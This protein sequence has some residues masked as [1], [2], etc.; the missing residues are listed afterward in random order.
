MK[1]APKGKQPTPESQ[2]KDAD[3]VRVSE[4]EKSFKFFKKIN[5]PRFGDI[6]II[7]N[8]QSREFL[9]VREKKINDRAE[10]GRQILAARQRISL[11]Y[12]HLLELKDYSVTKQSELCSSFYIIKLFYEYPRS[13]L[14][15]EMQ[16]RQRNGQPFSHVEL[17]HL[18]YQ[19]VG[20]QSYLQSHDQTHGDIQPL[21]IG[22]EK[23]TMNSKLIDRF[24]EPGNALKT[25]QI[26]KN[27][28]IAGHNLYQSPTMYANLKKGN[29]NFNFDPAK[30][31]A[32][33][34]GLVL[35]EAGNGQS[36]QN[37]YDSSKGTV[38]QVV[39]QK[40]VEEFNKK[41]GNDNALLSSSVASLVTFDEVSR[42]TARQIESSIPSYD[43]VKGFLTEN[44]GGQHLNGVHTEAQGIHLAPEVTAQQVSS[45]NTQELPVQNAN[46]GPS[47]FFSYQGGRNDV[48]PYIIENTQFNLFK[49]PDQAYV[50]S[51]PVQQQQTYVQSAPVQYQQESYVQSAPVQY[52]QSY[53]QSAPQQQ[54][55]SYST[56][57][58]Q[59]SDQHYYEYQAP[60]ESDSQFN[61]TQSRTL[62]AEPTSFTQYSQDRIYNQVAPVTQHFE[63]SV[64]STP[65]KVEY[66]S[67]NNYSGLNQDSNVQ[68]SLQ[69]SPQ[70]VYKTSYQTQSTPQSQYTSQR[71]IAEPRT[72]VYINGQ[73]QGQ[74]QPTDTSAFKKSVR[75]V[76]SYQYT[77]APP[78]YQQ[79][80]E[81]VPQTPSQT[82]VK[83][84]S[85]SYRVVQQAQS[86]YVQAPVTTT[87]SNQAEVKHEYRTADAN[88]VQPNVIRR[89]YANLGN[90]VSTPS[91]S[92]RVVQYAP[93]EIRRSFHTPQVYSNVQSVQGTYE[94]SNSY[95]T[96]QQVYAQQGNSE[97]YVVDQNSISQDPELQG[98]K[99][100]GSY[101]DFKNAT[102][103]PN[104]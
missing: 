65:Q 24:E 44:Q 45:R 87:Y 40:H 35:L 8:P 77:Q 81:Y 91:Y 89:S 9:A 10:A 68:Y 75:N 15:K 51:A 52:Q 22:W 36:V 99:L 54:N 62:N 5:D 47:D 64:Q 25:K 96:G 59:P 31:D 58:V 86:T 103:R 100:V 18:F 49:Q 79:T 61:Y 23:E 41:F 88:T 37:I 78:L 12:P 28:L 90:V 19:Q 101:T 14:R 72:I 4:L 76:Q 30:E 17:T 97:R 50:Q 98:L 33:A 2:L 92:S 80:A 27:R 60:K 16:E 39:L 85:N 55:L 73:L 34:L 67:Y 3:Y 83:Y 74:G 71:I 21:H 63:H 43:S 1:Q 57:K 48:N 70:A 46:T 32:F 104:Y 42:P 82:T 20:T 93:T 95:Y 26:Q 6:S 53:V 56:Q 13:D 66:S 69:G 94:N 84:P 29:L 11:K 102:D 38:D 7:Q